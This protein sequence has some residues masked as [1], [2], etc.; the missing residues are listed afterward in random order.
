ML[1]N[2]LRG[3]PWNEVSRAGWGDSVATAVSHVR[4]TWISTVERCWWDPG[5]QA[6]SHCAWGGCTEP[7]GDSKAPVLPT[8]SRE[9]LP[10]VSCGRTHA[11]TCCFWQRP[12]SGVA[13]LYRVKL[14]WN[15][16]TPDA[17]AGMCILSVMTLE[18]VSPP[19]K[20][21]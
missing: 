12:H 20:F 16:L 14:A 13:A 18:N 7:V 2:K 8:H 5:S 15:E 19:P 10:C 1:N 17:L 4:A 6:S 21:Q 9:G 3:W 11:C